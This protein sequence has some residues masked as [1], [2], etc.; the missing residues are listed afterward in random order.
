MR[1]CCGQEGLLKPLAKALPDPWTAAGARQRHLRLPLLQSLPTGHRQ[2]TFVA[3]AGTQAWSFCT[4]AAAPKNL[5][6]MIQGGGGRGHPYSVSS[7]Q[8]HAHASVHNMHHTGMEAYKH[9]SKLS[10]GVDQSSLQAAYRLPTG[11][12]QAAYR[13][14]KTGSSQHGSTAVPASAQQGARQ[15]ARAWSALSGPR[16]ASLSR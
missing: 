5:R 2:C 6:Y 10:G 14:P 9:I 13:L 3:T 8:M 11:C 7:I 1:G 12:L 4:A 15:P 16:G